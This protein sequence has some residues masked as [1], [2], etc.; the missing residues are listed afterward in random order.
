MSELDD[1]KKQLYHTQQLLISANAHIRELTDEDNYSDIQL[2]KDKYRAEAA[3]LRKHNYNLLNANIRLTQRNAEL[4]SELKLKDSTNKSLERKL[5]FVR[6]QMLDYKDKYSCALRRITQLREQ[7]ND[8]DTNYKEKYENCQAYLKAMT[9]ERDDLQIKLDISME[10]VKRY[11]N[12]RE[13]LLREKNDLQKE[14][15]R[16]DTVS[17][18]L[19]NQLDQYKERYGK[20]KEV[21]DGQTRE[22]AEVYGERAKLTKELTK[23]K[24][25]INSR[26]DLQKRVDSAEHLL[27][28]IKE[29]S[30]RVVS[31]ENSIYIISVISNYFNNK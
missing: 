28:D 5:T 8:G 27:R 25:T 6:T 15:T 13:R 24:E 4:E 30:S 12:V 17:T 22:L 11:I 16:L 18:Y 26:D 10:S 21:S 23:L 2:K 9:N 1:L 3:S 29:R 31:I 19:K 20:L 7:M 14:N